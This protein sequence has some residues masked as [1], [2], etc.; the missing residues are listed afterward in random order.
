MCKNETRGFVSNATIE[1][2]ISSFLYNEYPYCIRRA[3]VVVIMPCKDTVEQYSFNCVVV[4]IM[5][6]DLVR[7]AVASA[8]KYN[9]FMHLSLVCFLSSWIFKT[10]LEIPE[11]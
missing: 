8:V 4:N 3:A 5:Y 6:N 7:W 11:I 10:I 1:Q 2:T 9:C